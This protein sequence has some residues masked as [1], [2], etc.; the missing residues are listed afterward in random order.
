MNGGLSKLGSALIAVF[1][2]CFVVL[3]A[4]LVYVIWRRRRFQRRSIATGESVLAGD[5]IYVLSSKELLYFFCWKNRARVEPNEANNGTQPDPESQIP[6]EVDDLLKLQ[7]LYGESRLLFTIKEE[8]DEAERSEGLDQMESSY[9]KEE[10]EGSETSNYSDNHGQVCVG[11]TL[12]DDVAASV[13]VEV[14]EATPFSTPCA[15][16][17]YYTPSPSPSREELK[18]F[19]SNENIGVSYGHDDHH[20]TEKV[21]ASVSLE[22]IG[23]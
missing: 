22:I 20:G 18:Q 11:S 4:D 13:L 7:G 21:P 12:T 16:P 14:D 23:V 10:K 9:S 8:E 5:S 19:Y 1:A 2:V 17:P 15:S 3:V 6:V